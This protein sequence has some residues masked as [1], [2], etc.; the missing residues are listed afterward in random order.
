[1]MGRQVV[2]TSPLA[3]N[4][5]CFIPLSWHNCHEC[6]F[7]FQNCP[8]LDIIDNMVTIAVCLMKVCLCKDQHVSPYVKGL[9]S[10]LHVHVSYS[11]SFYSEWLSTFHLLSPLT[12]ATYHHFKP[13][14]LNFALFTYFDS[15]PLRL[16]H[17]PANLSVSP[18][19]RFETS[20]LTAQ[21]FSWELPPG[22]KPSS[23]GQVLYVYSSV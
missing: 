7:H 5:H 11:S 23:Q 17:H 10:N 22:D 15:S 19:F 6:L 8:G 21:S 4:N 14:A 9:W 16:V 12:L 1:M 18:S 3:Q 2:P 13:S 20:L